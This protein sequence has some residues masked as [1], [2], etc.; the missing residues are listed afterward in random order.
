MGYPIKMKIAAESLR[1]QGKT[2]NEIADELSI[3]KGTAFLWTRNIVLGARA[4]TRIS[5]L[6]DEARKK[7][8]DTMATKRSAVWEE[9]CRWAKREIG[10]TMN[11]KSKADWRLLA[12]I[13]YWCEGEKGNGS[14]IAFTN[15]DPSM[16][17]LFIKALRNGF[18]LGMQKFRA[19]LHIHEYHD[20]DSQRAYW[21][22]ITGIPEN[23]FYKEYIKPHTGKRKHENYPGCISIRYYDSRIA[24]KLKALYHTLAKDMGA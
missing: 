21:S 2:V 7:G 4:A 3:S 16:V 10:D 13:L 22:E 5:R 18:N 19:L 8:H 20:R 17:A 12:A 11:P 15:S 9:D 6:R 14:M 24:R 23:Q 1:R